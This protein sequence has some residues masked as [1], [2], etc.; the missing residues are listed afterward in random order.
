MDWGWRCG[1]YFLIGFQEVVDADHY[2]LI[3]PDVGFHCEN[4]FNLFSE[5]DRLSGYDFLAVYYGAR[6]SSWSWHN[7]V[8]EYFPETYG[9][10]FP[11]TR[12]SRDLIKIIRSGRQMLTSM[13]K[14]G[15][16]RVW[17]NDESFVA[18]I[19]NYLGLRAT[20][21]EK[22]FPGMFKMFGTK[23]QYLLGP[24]LTGQGIVHPE[25]DAT[26]FKEKFGR[27]FED[28]RR[29]NRLDAFLRNSLQ[30]ATSEMIQML[31]QVKI[32]TEV[33]GVELK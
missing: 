32:S 25:L 7:S 22:E 29:A 17:P 31:L 20:S 16:S 27:R 12:C 30:G 6:S 13:A 11:I 23:D 3:E 15:E 1:D 10:S 2:W 14:H 28:A 24:H 18:S 19:V 4:E 8:F 26:A 5:S 33:N 21:L 9:C